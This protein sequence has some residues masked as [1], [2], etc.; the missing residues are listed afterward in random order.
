ML[1]I[2]KMLPDIIEIKKDTTADT[3]EISSDIQDDNQKHQPSCGE[4]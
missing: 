1:V 2:Q 3:E 4:N